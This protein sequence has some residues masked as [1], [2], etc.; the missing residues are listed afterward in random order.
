MIHFQNA[1]PAHTTVVAPVWL[2]LSTPLTMTTVARALCL[3]KTKPQRIQ[4]PP[5]ACSC[6]LPAKVATFIFT[7]NSARMYHNTPHVAY[8]QHDGKHVENDGVSQSFFLR[9]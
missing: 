8:Y 1:L 2:V 7:W 4:E 9:C 3:L 6:I 5:R